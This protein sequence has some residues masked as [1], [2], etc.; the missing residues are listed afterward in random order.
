MPACSGPTTSRAGSGRRRSRWRAEIDR[1]GMRRGA[2]PGR[3]SPSSTTTRA[4]GPG[5]SS[6]RRRASA[7]SNLRVRAMYRQ[8]RK[9]GL[10]VDILSARDAR[11]LRLQARLRADALCLDDA[12]LGAR[13]RAAD[14]L[15]SSGRAPA[16][17]PRLSH[18]RRSAAG[19]SRQDC[20]TS[21]RARRDAS[22]PSSGAGER[23]RKCRQMARQDRDQ[24]VGAH[25][26]PRRLAGPRPAGALLLSRRPARRRG[27]SDGHAADRRSSP[28]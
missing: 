18:S 7:I 6:R 13:C 10:D 17:R 1:I 12:A 15:S 22:R 5:I 11:P 24:G 3:L 20:A 9:L 19:F 14:G 28:A 8:L 27:A 23:R 21:S 4:P 2:E 16:R 25:R 26:D